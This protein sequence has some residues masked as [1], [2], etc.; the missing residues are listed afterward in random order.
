MLN[1][2]KA[3]EFLAKAFKNAD[4]YGNATIGED[5]FGNDYEDDC[6]CNAIDTMLSQNMIDKNVNHEMCDVIRIYA[7]SIGS[8]TGEYLF[9]KGDNGEQ[10]ERAAFC[11]KQARLIANA[12]AKTK[13]K[14][15]ASKPKT[16]VKASSKTQTKTK[17]KQGAK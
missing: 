6:L 9:E 12:A 13:A 8:D 15:E 10:T 17:V 7:D 2:Q 16:K 4:D 14:R 1:K 11:R 5:E 3:W